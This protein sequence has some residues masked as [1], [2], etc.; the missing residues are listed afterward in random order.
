[1]T[2]RI[3]G[4]KSRHEEGKRHRKPIAEFIRKHSVT[5]SLVP[6]DKSLEAWPDQITK[7]HPLTSL[8]H[9]GAV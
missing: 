3:V 5:Q 8:A 4:K 2:E 1:M 9:P 6:R 7:I